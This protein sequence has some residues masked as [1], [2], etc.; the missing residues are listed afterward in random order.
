MKNLDK[1]F[2]KADLPWVNLVWSQY[3]GNS[4]VPD[5]LRKRFFWWRS[6][7]KLL[8]TYKGIARAEFGKGDRILF[9]YDLWNN[10]VLKLSFP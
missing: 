10:Q 5:N 7:L 3:Y 8:D 2:S 4:R 6:I 9:W 1:F